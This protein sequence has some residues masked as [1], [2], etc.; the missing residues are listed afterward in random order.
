MNKWSP[1]PFTNWGL[2]T[3]LA[4]FSEDEVVDNIKEYDRLVQHLH[5]NAKKAEGSRATKKCLSY[6]TLS[7]YASMEPREPQA[8]TS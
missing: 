8:T 2:F 7:W 3:S 5:D 1:K 4:D 6:E